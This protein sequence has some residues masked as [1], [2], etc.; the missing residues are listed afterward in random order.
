MEN[1]FFRNSDEVFESSI[2]V[3]ELV[4]ERPSTLQELRKL[5]RDWYGNLP[6]EILVVNKKLQKAIMEFELLCDRGILDLSVLSQ[7]SG[8]AV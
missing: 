8:S 3:D 4:A 1:L 5:V 7:D 6:V 2:E